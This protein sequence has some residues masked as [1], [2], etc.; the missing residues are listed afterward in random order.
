MTQ[1]NSVRVYDG[2][3]SE[4]ADQLDHFVAG[5]KAW[6]VIGGIVVS[7]CATVSAYTDTPKGQDIVQPILE[8]NVQFH[9]QTWGF[10]GE[11]TVSIID[12]VVDAQGSTAN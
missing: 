7:A 8:R 3:R 4:I 1:S 2:W 11:A 5:C 9:A 12:G 10:I 6:F